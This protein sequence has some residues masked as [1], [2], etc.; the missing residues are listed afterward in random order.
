M[1]WKKQICHTFSQDVI[2]K[3]LV[4]NKLLW[5]FVWPFLTNKNWHTQIDIMLTDNGDVIAEEHGLVETFNDYYENIVEK[6]LE[7][8]LAIMSQAKIN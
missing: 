1:K 2:K 7:K 3:G 4:T 5:K 6:L 8:K